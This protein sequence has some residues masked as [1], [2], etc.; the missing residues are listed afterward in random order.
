MGFFASTRLDARQVSVLA[1][2]LLCAILLLSLAPG[3]KGEAA[4]TKVDEDPSGAPYV[5]GEL[6]VLYEPGTSENIEQAVV[7]GSEAQTAKDLPRKVRLISFPGIRREGSRETRE[8]AL[9]RKLRNLRN[10]PHV[11][12]ADYNYMRSAFWVPNDPR[13]DDPGQWGLKKTTFPGAWND[14]RGAG[15]K[16]A[17]LDSGID[18]GHSDIG[19]I[20]AQKNFFNGGTDV[21]DRYGHGTHVA[22]IAAALTNNSRGVAG[23][24][25]GCK[26]LVAKVMDGLGGVEDANV[27]PAINWSVNQ[28]AD[29]INLSFGGSG[30]SAGNEVLGAAIND[31]TANGAVVVA[32]AGNE[33]G[34]TTKQ[35][36]AAYQKVIAVSATNEN[37]RLASFSS[38]GSW[39]DLAAPGANIL[40]TRAGGSYNEESGTS[41]SAPFVSALAGLLASEGKTA[42][43][44]RQRMQSTATDLG[45]AGDDPS[46]GHGRINANRAVP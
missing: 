16:I 23:G 24:C 44:I 8:R 27:I 28:G 45:P 20:A 36:P 14:A 39:V 5:A 34:A 10:E 15:A 41:E 32:A 38:R 11:E 19:N 25:P 26:L 35:Y 22:G 17:I 2:T 29:V 3:A 31:A 33:Y 6:L 4:Q 7:R 13:F 9:E 46:F 43:E 42:S 18:R 30:G 21:E 12:A 40:S 37:D 1:V